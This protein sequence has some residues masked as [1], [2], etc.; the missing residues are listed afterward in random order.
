MKRLSRR[1]MIT[2]DFIFTFVLVM[3]F[4]NILLAFTLTLTTVEVTQY[5]TFASARVYMGAHIDPARQQTLAI[6]KYQELLSRYST[7]YTGRWWRVANEPV[8]GHM[9]DHGLP[10]KRQDL[11]IGAGTDFRAMILE[12]EV[13]GFGAT[14]VNADGQGGTFVTFIGSYLGRES[15]TVECLQTV[16]QRWTKIRTLPVAGAAAY[17]Q[18]TTDNGYAVFDDNGC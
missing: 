5:I 15:T 3:V 17:S 16:Q 7:L 12:F 13:P 8:L 10:F 11:A 14:D 4:V 6:A 1:G 9:M 18:S 2:V